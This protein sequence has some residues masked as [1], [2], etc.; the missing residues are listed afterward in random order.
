MRYVLTTVI[1]SNNVRKKINGS[2]IYILFFKLFRVLLATKIYPNAY[3]HYK[4]PNFCY[5]WGGTLFC[6]F[7]V[8]SL[9]VI[10][11]L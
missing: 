6:T 4:A 2:G 10:L 11:A 3:I 5:L 8:L 7:D 9:L 1:K